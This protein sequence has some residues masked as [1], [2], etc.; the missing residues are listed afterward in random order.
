MGAGITG[1]KDKRMQVVWLQKGGVA[2][3]C[4]CW[5]RLGNTGWKKRKDKSRLV[6]GNYLFPQGNVVRT[7]QRQCKTK[8]GLECSGVRRDLSLCLYVWEKDPRDG[9]WPGMTVVERRPDMTT[10]V[11]VC[12]RA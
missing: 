12:T 7:F 4:L 10:S 1:A 9:L 3:C 11:L 5:K 8:R 2:H 6:L